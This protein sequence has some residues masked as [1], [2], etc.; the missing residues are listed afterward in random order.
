MPDLRIIKAAIV[1]E[2][3]EPRGA[4]RGEAH[5]VSLVD[6]TPA[7]LDGVAPVIVVRVV[8]PER[9]ATRLLRAAEELLP[10]YRGAPGVVI[11]DSEGAVR[12]VAPRTDLEQAVLH[13]RRRDYPAL[14]ERLGLR[15]DYRP[16]GRR[17]VPPLRLLAVPPVPTRPRPLGGPR[18]RSA[19]P[20]PAARPTRA[21]GTARPRR[22]VR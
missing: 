16:P 17:H 12:G 13:M 21:D 20:L 4:T 6:G 19:A 3:A 11:L 2:G 15:G 7:A 10:I 5:T 14:A 9:D 18:G 8:D 1:I 22:G